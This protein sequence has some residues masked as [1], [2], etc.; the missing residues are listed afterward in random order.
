MRRYLVVANQTL[1][2]ERLAETV[3]E[4]MAQDACHFHLLVPATHS[5]EYAV[6]VYGPSI[7]G[8][9]VPLTSDEK[10]LA[11]ARQ[12][13]EGEVQRLRQCGAS[14]DGS[15]GAADPLLAIRDALAEQE[16]DE[17]ILS[18]LPP[19][20][21]RWLR[22]DLPSRV[23]RKFKLPVTLVHAKPVQA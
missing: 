23:E 18:T 3:R 10:G 17:I 6:A 2:G 9:P 14:V 12:R 22:V 1:G 20:L 7:A 11:M 8:V 16:F 21:S 5:A 13:L 4:R 19:G 15:V